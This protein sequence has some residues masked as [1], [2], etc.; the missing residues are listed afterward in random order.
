MPFLD[1]RGTGFVSREWY[2]FFLNMVRGNDDNIT[3][4]SDLQITPDINSI[5]SAYDEAVQSLQQGMGTQPS[6]TLGTVTSV[7][8][9]TLGT[10]GTDLSSSVSNEITDPEITLNVP[11]ASAVNRGA[12]S[13]ADWSIFN[14]KASVVTSTWTPVAVNL[15]TVGTVTLAGNYTMLEDLVF[16]EIS[17]TTSGGGTSASTAGV[18]TLTL[19]STADRKCAAVCVRDDVVDLGAALVDTSGVIYLPTW[20]AMSTGVRVSGFYHD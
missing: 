18:T 5:M 1:A 15:T 19:P 10:S 4:I 6:A 13:A 11:T 12:L 8:A 9:L 16:F 17:I 2:L 20:V 7:A 3:S 14:A